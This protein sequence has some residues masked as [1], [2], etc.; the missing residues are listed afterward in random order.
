MG[1]DDRWL[2]WHATPRRG[3]RPSVP[4]AKRV[5]RAA[6]R[7]AGRVRQHTIAERER[8]AR[9]QAE[10]SLEPQRQEARRTI[11]GRANGCCG[12]FGSDQEALASADLSPPWLGH[13]RLCSIRH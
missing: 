2:S 8:S 9:A 7:A 3:W 4:T 5:W 11:A 6:V 10:Q 13:S 1:V 12:G